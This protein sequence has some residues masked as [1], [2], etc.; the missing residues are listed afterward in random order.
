LLQQIKNSAS[1]EANSVCAVLYCDLKDEN[2]VELSNDEASRLQQCVRGL[3]KITAG[4]IASSGVMKR[5]LTDEQFND[6]IKSFDVDFSHTES[7]E[8]GEIPWQ[9]NEYF[10]K[11]RQGDKFTRTANMFKRS[12]KRDSNGQT[13]YK[14]YLKKAE[15]CYEDAVMML[16]NTV[17]IDPTRNPNVDNN[18]ATEISR[19]LDRDVNPE[20][21]YEP[22]ACVEGV[23]RLRGARSKYTQVKTT[24]VVGQR[25]RKYLRQREALT[26]SALQ[27]LY[28][29]VEE[30]VNASE[31]QSK[32]GSK[33]LQLSDDDDLF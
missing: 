19:W 28:S 6:Y 3:E 20:P 25:R 2:F 24:Q 23:P 11:V 29:E 12:T 1:T 32:I 7:D 15:S 14:R 33:L 8:H 17:D 5:A 22:N 18:V 9:L 10:E 16:I 26:Q 13:A 21:G 4:S 31:M 30:D 27:L